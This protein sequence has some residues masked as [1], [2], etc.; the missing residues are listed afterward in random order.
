[1]NN[2]LPARCTHELVIIWVAI[3]ESSA[4][5]SMAVSFTIELLAPNS[6]TTYG[7]VISTRPTRP[8]APNRRWLVLTLPTHPKEPSTL[9][10]PHMSR[11]HVSGPLVWDGDYS[12]K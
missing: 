6:A 12:L 5:S 3:E 1:M 8:I 10:V 4:V 11:K 2:D 9:A 7:F